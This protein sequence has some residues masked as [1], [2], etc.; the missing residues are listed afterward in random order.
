M[1]IGNN[2]YR[3]PWCSHEFRKEKIAPV[4]HMQAKKNADGTYY[5]YVTNCPKCKRTISSKDK[6]GAR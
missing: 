6:Y 5:P 3:C 2:K 1:K 4:I